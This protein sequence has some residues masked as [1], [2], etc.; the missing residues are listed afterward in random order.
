MPAIKYTDRLLI[1]QIASRTGLTVSSVYKILSGASGFSPST[2]ERVE[3]M[4]QELQVRLPTLPASGVFTVGVLIPEHPTYFW[5][6]AISGIRRTVQTLREER[7][8]RV[9]TVFRFVHFP[10][11]DSAVEAALEPFSGEGCNAYI[12][13][14]ADCPAF[15]RFFTA[16]PSG[17]PVVLFNDLPEDLDRLRTLRE[18]PL[19]VYVGADNYDEGILAAHVLGARLSGM[20]NVLAFLSDDSLGSTAA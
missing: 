17:V 13:Y 15:L 2:R 9:E 16:I 14:P 10:I 5:S 3:R 18:R 6:E 19:T 1:R 8:I 11:S 7:G 20:R 12:L 4:A